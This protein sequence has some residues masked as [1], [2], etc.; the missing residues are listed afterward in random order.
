MLDWITGKKIRLNLSLSP[1]CLEALDA[2]ADHTK[3]SRSEV[4][5]HLTQG[6]LALNSDSAA[7]CFKATSEGVSLESPAASPAPAPA[8]P[9]SNPAT[10]VQSEAGPKAEPVQ[11][12]PEQAGFKPDDADPGQA[13]P[14]PTVERPA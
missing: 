6:S 2:I 5:E 1:A 12:T 9:P 3:L 14:E 13:A 11:E 7:T 10:A 4:L 8:A